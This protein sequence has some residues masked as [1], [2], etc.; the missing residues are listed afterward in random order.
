MLQYL[1]IIPLGDRDVHTYTYL[2][3]YLTEGSVLVE[4]SG[5][6]KLLLIALA[7]HGRNKVF[8]FEIITDLFDQLI[9]LDTVIYARV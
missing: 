4:T 2:N 1:Y 9:N 3:F 8:S 7:S 5:L 6:K